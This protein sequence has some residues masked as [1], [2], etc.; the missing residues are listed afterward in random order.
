MRQATFSG[1]GP[2][3][4]RPARSALA[5]VLLGIVTISYGGLTPAGAANVLEGAKEVVEIEVSRGKLIR[6]DRPASDIF[7]ANPAIADI[8][9]KSPNLVYLY[10]KAEGETAIYAL[11]ANE[12]MIYSASVLITQNVQSARRTIDRLLPDATVNVSAASGM[13]FLSG[14]VASPE[15]SEVAYRVA[16]SLVQNDAERIVNRLAISTPTQINL[17][18]KIAEIGRGTLKQLGFNWENIASPGG[19]ALFGLTQGADV[20][21]P[22]FDSAGNVIRQDFQVANAGT[23]SFFGSIT[24]GRFDVNTVVDALDNEGFLSVLAEPNLTALSGETATFLAG[25]EFP[26]PVPS[27]GGGEGGQFTVEFKE[28]GVALAFTPTVLSENKINLQVSPEV[29]Q[30]SNAGAVSVNGITIPA[31]TTRRVSTTVE[32]ASGQSFAIA[33]LLQ[34]TVTHDNSRTPGLGDIPILGAL[35]RSDRFQ[36]QETELVVIV[37]PYIVRPFEAARAVLPTDGLREPND[38]QRYLKGDTFDKSAQPIEPPAESGN[39]ITLAGSAGFKL[40]K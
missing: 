38:M 28:F 39:N 15:E 3:I 35:F 27:G 5:A 14:Y 11:D 17:R 26:V 25:G 37:T 4:K 8:Q 40:K 16:L 12:T 34:D 2:S 1:F 23:N 32:L 6:L 31:L 13:I 20:I 7:V 30:L 19:G 21:V 9:V 18:V 36:R 24:G 22:S 29:S 33:G 10:G